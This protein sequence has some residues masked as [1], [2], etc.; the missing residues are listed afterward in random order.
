MAMM[1]MTTS[2]SINVN[3]RSA[4]VRASVI[5]QHRV[6]APGAQSATGLSRILA[7]RHR[8]KNCALPEAGRVTCHLLFA[9]TGWL[10]SVVQL[11]L[12]VGLAWTENPAAATG[13]LN[14]ML[15][16]LTETLSDGLVVGSALGP[17]ESRARISS[18]ASLP[19]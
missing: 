5:S 19:R 9:S 17:M 10:V 8:R 3:A 6:V 14:V 16:P 7:Q 15:P 2:N 1:A 18:G 4:R 12:I 11:P 13:Q